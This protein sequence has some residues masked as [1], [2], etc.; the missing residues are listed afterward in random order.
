MNENPRKEFNFQEQKVK[1]LISMIRTITPLVSVIREWGRVGNERAELK[2]KVEKF[3]RNIKNLKDV[4]TIISNDSAIA[5]IEEEIR[6]QTIELADSSRRNLLSIRIYDSLER[7]IINYRDY[8]NHFSGIND[9]IVNKILKLNFFENEEEFIAMLC[10]F[11]SID[12]NL[13]DNNKLLENAKENGFE[14]GI[15]IIN[16][17]RGWNNILNYLINN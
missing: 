13:C 17:C 9:T 7:E 11:N 1:D 5:V 6:N 14:E 12:S 16:T 3:N 10:L 15:E 4:C 8:M 2:A